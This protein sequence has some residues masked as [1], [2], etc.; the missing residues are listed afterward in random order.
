[1]AILTEGA[2]FGDAILSEANG[3]RSR[4]TVSVP[5]S[6][7]IVPGQVL[8]LIAA[9]SGVDVT[10]APVPGNTGNG[11]IAMDATPTTS[12]A[13]PGVYSVIFTAATAFKVE[14]PSGREVGT[15]ATASAFTKEVRFTITAGGTAYAVGDRI[16]ITVSLETPDDLQAV[17]YDPTKSDGSEVAS[18]VAIGGAVTASGET[19]KVVVLARD[20]EVKAPE[21]GW[22]AGIAAAAKAAAIASLAERGII[23]R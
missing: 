4:E 6:T 17:P 23:V 14:D 7:T 10:T 21:L 16:Q 12:K 1:M 18:A 8:A 19:A 3:Y 2:H 11:T 9:T 15:G 22:P 5:A 20:A 13:K